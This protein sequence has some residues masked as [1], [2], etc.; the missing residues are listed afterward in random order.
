MK[1][2]KGKKGDVYGQVHPE[3]S[4]EFRLAKL[5]DF[6]SVLARVPASEKTN[7]FEAETRCP[8]LLTAS[9]K[10]KFLRCDVFDVDV[11]C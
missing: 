3:E 7:V 4:M 9:F 6:D 2:T 5:K 8:E 10:L 11:S 1:E